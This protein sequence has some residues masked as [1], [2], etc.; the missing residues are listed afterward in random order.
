MT[1]SI[2][3]SES[4]A[5][6]WEPNGSF[7]P[8]PLAAPGGACVLIDFRQ[9]TDLLAMFGGE[10]N[11][12]TLQLG[13][14]HSGRGLYASYTDMP[15]EGATFLGVSDQ[16]AL[17]EALESASTGSAAFEQTRARTLLAHLWRKYDTAGI[18]MGRSHEAVVLEAVLALLGD[19]DP[20]DMALLDK[21][22][23]DLVNATR[24]YLS[25]KMAQRMFGRSAANEANPAAKAKEA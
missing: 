19:P 15:E 3:T 21:D 10:P 14:G 4:E 17:P 7:S 11:E 25:S 5:M 18:S 23:G 20:E 24:T 22:S 13:D 6:P 16:E 8:K 12:I 9:A 1:E 2:E